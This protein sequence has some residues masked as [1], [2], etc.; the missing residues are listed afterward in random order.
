MVQCLVSLSEFGPHTEGARCHFL[1]A[2]GRVA[3][4][5][6]PGAAL[7]VSPR[8]IVLSLSVIYKSPKPPDPGATSQGPA[9]RACGLA[10]QS[11]GDVSIARFPLRLKHEPCVG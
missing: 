7:V 6:P 8:H 11:R 5:Q 9:G 3:T 10:C 2:P 1:F 4:G